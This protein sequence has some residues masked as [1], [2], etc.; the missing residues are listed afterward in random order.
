MSN[1]EKKSLSSSAYKMKLEQMGMSFD[2]TY[3]PESYYEKLYLTT[4]NA[5][6]KVTRNNTPFYHEKM[7]NKK[8]E[9]ESNKKKKTS[10]NKINEDYSS[11]TDEEINLKENN[12]ISSRKRKNAKSQNE[13]INNENDTSSGIKV[14]RL[15]MSR[16]NKDKR[17]LKNNNDNF[18]NNEIIDKL[19][20]PRARRS[21][22]DN[23]NRKNDDYIYYNEGFY[24]FKSKTKS[25]NKNS[26]KKSYKEKEKKLINKDIEENG[27]KNDSESQ[28]NQE[29]NI[30]NIAAQN[31]NYNN[32]NKPFPEGNNIEQTEN[33][34]PEKYTYLNIKE[35][36]NNQNSIIINESYNFKNL[37]NN[38]EKESH[39]NNLNIIQNNED[40]E[41]T[42]ETKEVNK[43]NIDISS[44]YSQATSLFSR[45]SAFSYLSFGKIE[46]GF[47]NM[48]N[49]IMNKF[50]K[51]IYL[52]PLIL[53]ILFGIIF[54]LNERYENLERNNI[55]IIFSVIMGLI[56]L[57][58][59][60]K[61]LK[62]I[63]KYKKIAKED[64]KKLMEML[65]ENGIKKED[66]GNNFILLSEF[67]EGIIRDSE[68][69]YG[70]YMNYVFPYLVKYLRK[71]G[72]ILE[73]QKDEDLE[74][75]NLNYWKKM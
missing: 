16:H 6:N 26:Q 25:R 45:F 24:R 14:T 47:V 20:S 30:I 31:N 42:P 29:K 39:Q 18:K 15:I 70:I 5:K 68:L 72:Y 64:K 27:I 8:R 9:R 74:D 3:H 12:I 11:V 67:F 33:G 19:R 62:D 37:N 48:K 69:D 59:L 52:F 10:R 46:S 17:I 41:Q 7:I 1:K 51:N 38:T 35:G 71:D 43:E 54:F 23:I 4:S 58:H 60:Y 40:L 2:R 55:I 28:E 65:E 49:C 21:L 53:L 44:D 36:Q 75:N 73:K 56:V 50:R 13:N 63:L 61:Y 57:F 22:N 34:I 32:Y 66:I